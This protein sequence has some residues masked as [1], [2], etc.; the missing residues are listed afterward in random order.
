MGSLR[1]D[2][3]EGRAVAARAAGLMMLAGAALAVVSV[4][5]PPRA[6]GSDAAV[7]TL[8]AIA[9]VFGGGLLAL[10]RTPSERA[11]GVAVATGTALITLATHEGGG[12]ETGTQDNEMLYLWICLL[13]FNFLTLR[14]ALAQLSLVAAA[15]AL[16]LSGT[17]LGE[18]LTRWLV[19]ISTLLLA[20]LLV[21]RLRS[22][23][24]RL[25]GELSKRA[26]NDGLTGLL[27]RTALEE[28]AVLELARVRRDDTALSL[29]V[30]D[31][32][33]FKQLND[34]RGHPVGDEVLRSIAR[35]LERETRAVDAIARLGGDEFA[36]LLPGATGRE[37]LTV[38]HR[39]RGHHR[40]SGSGVT[41]S[42]GVAEG[43][44]ADQLFETLWEEADSHMYEA[45]RD[46]GDAV[47]SSVG[48]RS[49][50][51]S[52]ARLSSSS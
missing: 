6:G 21:A 22:S 37:A 47:H 43:P 30:L 46:G 16:L 39:L 38:A 50:H 14:H 17:P 4:L 44:P 24:E 29:I 36:I 34:T 48:C 10:R 15:Y 7:L 40:A 2:G 28:R 26:R 27:N 20:G 11:L 23:R 41:L 49:W 13:A 52:R 8:G 45:K 32:D 19:S 18:G 25:V 31:I 1:G 35:G 51:G 33:K 9:A 3:Y 12:T 5:L 42:I